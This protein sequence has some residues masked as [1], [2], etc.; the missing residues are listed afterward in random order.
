MEILEI[1]KN[2]EEEIIEHRRNLHKIPELGLELPQT[3]KY[4]MDTLD[5]YGIEYEF[6]E[7]ISAVVGLIKGGHEGKTLGIRADMDGLPINE[8]TGLPYSST[9]ENMHACGHD[10]H[11]AILLGTAKILKSMEKDLHGNIKLLFQPGEEYP[12]GAEPMIKRGALENPKVDGVIGLHEGVIDPT[13]PKGSIGISYGPLMASMDRFAIEIIG[14]GGHG[15][16]PQ[17]TIDSVT[18]ACEIV[19]A[20]NDI[21]S[22]EVKATEPAVL[23]VCRIQGG[24][25]QNI[26][27]DKVELEGTVRATNEDVRR[28]I[29]RRIEE[30]A[31][32]IAKAK[33]AKA[34]VEYNYKYPATIN[35]KEFTEFFYESAKKILPKEKILVLDK[36]LM[37]GEDMSFFLN[38]VPGTYFFLSNPKLDENPFAHH[39]SQFDIEESLLHIGTALFVQT[40]IDFLNEGGES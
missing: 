22:R 21:V 23:S 36:P 11:A 26:L 35:N 27:P 18:T 24:F 9:N 17:D 25:N 19:T 7:D 29:A 14:R 37:G 5:E 32:N 28:F 38:E 40:A 12:G 13:V 34:K 4:I 39:T 6:Y 2:V 3:S 10:G 8:E 16:Y 20:L 1:A 30:I 31:V 33:G 15:A